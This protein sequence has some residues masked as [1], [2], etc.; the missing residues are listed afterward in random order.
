M[1]FTPRPLLPLAA[2]LALLVPR[3]AAGAD[4]D[5]ALQHEDHVKPPRQEV[6]PWAEFLTP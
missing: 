4:N 2:A 6:P 3:A 1:R 5:A